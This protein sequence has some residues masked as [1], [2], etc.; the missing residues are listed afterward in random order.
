MFVVV[1]DEI[2]IMGGQSG[3]VDEI[4][5]IGVLVK[6]PGTE[7]TIAVPFGEKVEKVGN[8][9]VYGRLTPGEDGVDTGLVERLKTWRLGQARSQ[10]VPA[11]V[12]FNDRTLDALAA[13][14]PGTEEALLEI[15]GIG[16]A[17]LEA[18][19]DQLLDMLGSA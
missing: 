14:R 2:A 17:K 12:V 18:Y 15:P 3:V 4:L 16:P 1:G 9:G 11:Y 10:G 7:A 6:L 8:A 13:L 5:T 19:G